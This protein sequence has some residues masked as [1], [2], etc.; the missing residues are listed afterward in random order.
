SLPNNIQDEVRARWGDP[1]DDPYFRED[2]FALPFARFG[3]VL[4][5]IQRPE[6]RLGITAFRQRQRLARQPLEIAVLAHMDDGM[7]T[8]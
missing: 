2:V 7:G 1:E 4:V 8:E 6:D 3:E 5:G